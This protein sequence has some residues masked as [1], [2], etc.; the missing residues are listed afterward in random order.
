[1]CKSKTSM[2]KLILS[3]IVLAS[4][5]TGTVQADSTLISGPLLGG[6][7]QNHVICELVNAGSTPIHIL[8]NQFVGNFSGV[9]PFLFFDNCEAATLSPGAFCNFQANVNDQPGVAPNQSTLCKVVILESKTNVRGTIVAV[10]PHI[11]LPPLD[12][13]DLR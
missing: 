1:M 2:R 4:G 8:S 7:E 9:F 13:A 12:R 11:G 5:M 10:N 6:V 3:G